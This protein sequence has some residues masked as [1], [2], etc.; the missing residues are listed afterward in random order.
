MELCLLVQLARLIAIVPYEGYLPY[1]SSGDWLYQTIEAL[2]GF[3]C[4]YM[5]W[6]CRIRYDAT[7]DSALDDFDI[8]LLVVPCLLLAIFFHPD[9][10]DCPVCDTL[11]SFALYLES[12]A[13]IPQLVMFQREK[14]IYPWTAHFLAAQVAVKVLSFLF[15]ANTYHE[16]HV[17]GHIT[18]QYVG[19]GVFVAQGVQVLLMGD[20][21]LQYVKAVSS[22]KDIQ[23]S[24]MQLLMEV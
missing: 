13:G 10:D 6:L 22:G 5:V 20:F 12:L 8:R 23:A 1:D 17:E 2:T 16:L 3:F 15:W 18:R 24:D 7:C 9:L 11:W 14:R 19:Y 4:A 21:C